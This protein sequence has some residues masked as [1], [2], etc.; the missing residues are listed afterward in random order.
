MQ[1]KKITFFQKHLTELPGKKVLDSNIAIIIMLI[2]GYVA[3]WS[4]NIYY[5]GDYEFFSEFEIWVAGVLGLII[6]YVLIRIELFKTSGLY[7]LIGVIMILMSFG[8]GLSLK[9]ILYLS[10]TLLVILNVVWFSLRSRRVV[11]SA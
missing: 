7:F 8:G 5:F 11:E 9:W 3:S 6:S 1:Q 10:L 2:L 4:L